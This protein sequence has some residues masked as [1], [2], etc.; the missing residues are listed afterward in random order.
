MK[1]A[2]F[3][4]LYHPHQVGG[5]EKIAQILAEGLKKF[6]KVTV[7]VVT[8][9]NIKSEIKM[10]Y[11]NNIKVYRVPMKNLYHPFLEEAKFKKVLKPLWHLLDIYNPLYKNFVKS[12]LLSEKIDIVHTHNLA[13]FSPI[14][15][16]ISKKLN[17]KVV[18]TL[19]DYYLLCPR[20]TMYK[21]KP[22]PTQCNICKAYSYFKKVFSN[23]Y[24]DAVIGVSRFVLDL[25]IK[26]DYFLNSYIKD[27]IYNPVYLTHKKV[28]KKEIKEITFGFI[29]RI[30]KVKGIEVLLNAVEIL[31][32]KHSNFKLLIAG[33]GNLQYIETLKKRFRNEKVKFLGFIKPE[34]FY[35]KID[36]LVVPSLWYEPLPT[37]ILEAFAY[38]V[39]VIGSDIG[40]IPELIENGRTGFIFEP[41]NSWELSFQM[42]KFI[43]NPSLKESMQFNLMGME[44]KFEYKK[45]V[46]DY[47]RIYQSL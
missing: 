26:N 21:N 34:E 25:H 47:M 3:S 32:R 19:H 46:N 33:K 17:L 43:L 11:I 8:T 16:E 15:W 7:I 38:K 39:P 27:V 12:I 41:G 36:I 18:H 40:G 5:A 9:N 37:V 35:P 22:C 20:A 10:E 23:K 30:E 1:I 24:V 42:E 4:N 29:G 2:I 6:K 44:E 13:G 14:V 28:A 45:F 31:K